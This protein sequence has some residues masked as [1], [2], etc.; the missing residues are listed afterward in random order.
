M[1]SLVVYSSKSG[2]TQKL[3]ESVYA[4]LP[5][6]KVLIPIEENPKNGGYDLIVVGFWLQGGKPDPTASKYLADLEGQATLFLL[7]THG[8]ATDS[9]HARKGMVAARELA[10]SS[11]ILGT[12][13]CQ[14]EVKPAFLAKAQAMAPPPPWIKDAASAAGHPDNAD[15]DNLLTAIQKIVHQVS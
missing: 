11:R 2:N 13:H 14:G 12:F 7:A 15:I 1:K 9:E 10:S 4:Y 5:G 8:A 3:A 6:E